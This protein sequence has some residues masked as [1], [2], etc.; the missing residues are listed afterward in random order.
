MNKAKVAVVF[1]IYNGAKTMK[2]SLDCIANQD[3]ADFRAIIVDNKSTDETNQIARDYCAQDQRFELHTNDVHLSAVDNFLH[4]M[5]IGKDRADYFCLRACDDFSSDNFLSSLSAALD[6]HPD[7][8][9]AGPTI[10]RVR[11]ANS[12][13]LRPDISIFEYTKSL[14]QG[15]VPRSLAFPAEWCYG[16]IRS[17]GGADVLLRRWNEYPFAWCVASYAVAELVMLDKVVWAEDAEYIFIEG[18]GSFEKY[19]AKT[20]LDKFRQ[21]LSYTYGCYKVSRRIPAVS[22]STRIQLFRRLWRDSRIKTRYDLEDHF[23]RLMR[24]RR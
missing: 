13:V 17:E 21:R 10:R 24:L 19:G 15:I 4:C 16:L 11:D 5:K 3:L 12:R 18:S 23:L 22:L 2:E 8:L 9:L 1:P 6:A 14:S 20:F 7:K